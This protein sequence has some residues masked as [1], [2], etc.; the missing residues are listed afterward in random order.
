[1]RWGPDEEAER[2]ASVLV[3]LLTRPGRVYDVTSPDLP[4]V[5]T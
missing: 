4:T 2:K 3:A 1:V 5:R